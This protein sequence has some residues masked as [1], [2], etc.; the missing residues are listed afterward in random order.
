MDKGGQAEDP[1]A[2]ILPPRTTT[3]VVVHL[4]HLHFPTGEA[5]EEA[6]ILTETAMTMPTK[7]YRHGRQSRQPNS[8]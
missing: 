3:G 6:A 1:I 4:V 5:A 2:T 8:S 7:R